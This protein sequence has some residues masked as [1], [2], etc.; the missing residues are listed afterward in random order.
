MKTS[1][2]M[3]WKFVSPQMATQLL[4]RNVNRKLRWPFIARLKSDIGGGSY[5]PTH[6]AIGIYEDGSLCD[7]QHRLTAIAESGVGQWMWICYGIPLSSKLVIDS[8]ISRTDFDQLVLSGFE[9]TRKSVEIVKCNQE[10]KTGAALKMTRSEIAEFCERHREALAFTANLTE[11]KTRGVRQ[12]AIGAVIFRATYTADR[13]RLRE[14]FHVL[15]T[16]EYERG[17]DEAA[18]AFRNY[19]LN[20]TKGGNSTQRRAAYW[21]CESA[22]MSF[23]Q[24]NPVSKI[25][26]ASSEQFPLP[27]ETEPEA[28][29]AA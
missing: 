14:F 3:E 6:Q 28:I 29:K 27:E 21:K 5:L 13:K 20:L 10:I 25:Y 7:G 1:M 11:T 16:G 8:G 26:A 2:R 24:R 4:E 17:S 22:L 12:A 18:L 23:L 15:T 19:L 9:V